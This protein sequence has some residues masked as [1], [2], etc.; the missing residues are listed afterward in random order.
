MFVIGFIIGGFIGIGIAL[1]IV[2][3]SV[4]KSNNLG[5]S[6]GSFANFTSRPIEILEKEDKL[7]KAPPLRHF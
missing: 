4:D 5:D 1:I 3:S 7:R 6:K 2:A